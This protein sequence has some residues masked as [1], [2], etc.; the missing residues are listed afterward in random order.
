MGKRPAS[1]KWSSSSVAVIPSAHVSFIVPRATPVVPGTD[2]LPTRR[3]LGELTRTGPVP[4]AA[5]V[6]SVRSL[7]VSFQVYGPRPARGWRIVEEIRKGRRGTWKDSNE[8]R[9]ALY[10]AALKSGGPRVLKSLLLLQRKAPAIRRRSAARAQALLPVPVRLE[11][12]GVVF[13]PLD[14]DAMVD[15]N[16]VY[17]D[18]LLASMIGAT[19][20]A[21]LLSHELHHIGR[22]LLTGENISGLDPRLASRQLTWTELIRF[23]ASLLEMEGIADMVFDV[24]DLSLPS[25]RRAMARRDRVAS[26]YGPHLRRVERILLKRPGGPRAGPGAMGRAMQVVLK[27]AHPLGKR[28]AETIRTEFGK[29]SLVRSVGHP[30]RFF[31]AYQDA[32]VAARSFQFSEELLA[33]I[34]Y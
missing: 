6:R 12:A 9:W 28:M 18:P 30:E 5:R 22:F 7:G 1:W 2:T 29:Q 20:V 23:W 33:S 15:G 13:T 26:S 4:S 32:A 34:P 11:R 17:F 21:R 16:T 31:R 25:Y 10:L 8:R 27:D 19:G 24:R 3:L 14:Y